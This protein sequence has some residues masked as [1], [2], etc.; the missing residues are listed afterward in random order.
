MTLWYSRKT[1]QDG[2][3]QIYQNCKKKINKFYFY[4]WPSLESKFEFAQQMSSKTDDLRLRYTEKCSN[5]SRPRSS[6]F[7]ICYLDHITCDCMWSCFLHSNFRQWHSIQLNT[8]Y[9]ASLIFVNKTTWR[10]CMAMGDKRFSRWRPSAILD[11]LW[12][13]HIASGNCILCFQHC[14]KCSRRLISYF[15]NYFDFGISTLWLGNAY[16]GLNLDIFGANWVTFEM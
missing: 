11:L 2:V 12:R 13:H 10:W 4:Q 16:L 15:R 6:I 7:E 5:G 1:L 9:I 8:I 3:R 14:V